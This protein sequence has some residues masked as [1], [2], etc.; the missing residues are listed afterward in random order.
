MKTFWNWATQC[1]II[2]SLL[3]SVK[4]SLNDLLWRWGF[5]FF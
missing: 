5:F 4:V 2:S 3:A 1:F